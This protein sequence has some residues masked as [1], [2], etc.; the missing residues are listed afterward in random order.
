MVKK[1]QIERIV[2]GSSKNEH[3]SVKTVAHINPLHITDEL[4]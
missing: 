4:K 3:I 1:Y 2:A